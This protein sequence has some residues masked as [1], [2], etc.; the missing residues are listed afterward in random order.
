MAE[1]T[2]SKSGGSEAPGWTDDNYA[3]D[4]HY[5]FRII[6]TTVVVSSQAGE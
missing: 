5:S 2:Q 6:R 3:D 4:V 1:K